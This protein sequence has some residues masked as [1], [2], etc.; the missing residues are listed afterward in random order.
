MVLPTYWLYRV[1]EGIALNDYSD[2]PV[3]VLMHLAWCLRGGCFELLM[4]CYV[5]LFTPLSFDLSC[6]ENYCWN[7][8]TLRKKAEIITYSKRKN[9]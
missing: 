5:H 2:F 1:F 9:L 6:S 3:A 7:L 4:D 8:K